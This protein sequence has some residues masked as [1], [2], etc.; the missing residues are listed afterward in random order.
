M[1]R[2]RLKRCHPQHRTRRRAHPAVTLATTAPVACLL[3]RS[4]VQVAHI[5]LLI[6]PCQRNAQRAPTARL[7]PPLSRL[8]LLA[9]SASPTQQTL[10]RAR[11]AAFVYHQFQS[12]HRAMRVHIIP[13]LARPALRHASLVLLVGIV[14]LV[15]LRLLPAQQTRTALLTGVLMCHLVWLALLGTIALVCACVWV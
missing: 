11:R 3:A 13:P 8:A 2:F 9:H 1:A 6:A 14:P 4:F 15:P 12:H 5:A 7:A 10:R